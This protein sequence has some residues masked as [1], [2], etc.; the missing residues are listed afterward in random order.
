MRRWLGFLLTAAVIGCS[1]GGGTGAPSVPAPKKPAMGALNVK[2]VIPSAAAASSVRL[3]K[4]LSAAS[5][6]N[7][8][9]FTVYPHGGNP[10]TQALAVSGADLSSTSPNCTTAGTTR[11][12]TVALAAPVSTT[13]DLLAQTYDQIVPVSGTLPAGAHLLAAATSPNISV[14]AGSSNTVSL[15]LNPVLATVTLSAT[16]NA[17]HAVLPVSRISIS[18]LGYDAGGNLI[19]SGSYVDSNGNPVSV[20]LST[21]TNNNNAF[22]LTAGPITGSGQMAGATYNGTANSTTAIQVSSAAPFASTLNVAVLSPT[23]FRVA[24]AN[25][26]GTPTPPGYMGIATLRVGSAT[27]VFYNT[28][29]DTVDYVN[30]GGNGGPGT[31]IPASQ[32]PNPTTAGLQTQGGLVNDTAAQMIFS[33]GNATNT[34][35]GYVS[36]SPPPPVPQVAVTC[37]PGGAPAC[38]TTGGLALNTS[39]S[40]LYYGSGTNI[41]AW[42]PGGSALP[43]PTPSPAIG[44]TPQWGGFNYDPSNSFVWGVDTQPGGFV[45]MYDGATTFESGALPGSPFDVATDSNSM[46]AWVTVPSLKKI[47][48]FATPLS[49]GASAMTTLTGTS[50]PQYITRTTSQLWVSE[51]SAGGV[52]LGHIDPATGAYGEFPLT[53]NSGGIAGPI[54]WLQYADAFA[55]VHYSGSAAPGEVLLVI[56]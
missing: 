7:G 34:Q 30:G 44:G 17:V 3:R 45:Y 19:L 21:T 36:G 37:A 39:S 13:N 23:V 26:A 54:I 1:G 22:T 25:L 29:S 24:D 32:T 46:N 28:P 6:T 55:I 51:T 15:T 14:V 38:A 27:Y 5:T 12:C 8:I 49:N 53:S 18:I 52:V 35:F 33:G 40:Q 42:T 9:L 20:T 43:I 50:S 2:I 10:T 4:A 47:L 48:E 41:Y 16:P 31:S 11:T 56:P